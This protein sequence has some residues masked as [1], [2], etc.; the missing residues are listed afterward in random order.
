MTT[1]SRKTIESQPTGEHYDWI[2]ETARLHAEASE[3]DHEVGDLQEAL[4]V[5]F[6]FLTESEQ[7]KVVNILHRQYDWEILGRG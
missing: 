1:P 2:L 6:A 4:R 3:P 7:A 5:A